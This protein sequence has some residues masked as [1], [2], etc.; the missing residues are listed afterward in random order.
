MFCNGNLEPDL[1]ALSPKEYDDY[2][3]SCLNK[4]LSLSQKLSRL[5]DMRSEF[6]ADNVPL[7]E[8]DEKIKKTLDKLKQANQR[9]K[10][11]RDYNLPRENFDATE[12]HTNTN[13]NSTV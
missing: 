12:S 8:V 5:D 9:L 10:Q 1:K 13:S 11:V 6:M 7:E 4:V 3:I 2:Q